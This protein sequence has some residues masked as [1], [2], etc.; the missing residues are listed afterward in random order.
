MKLRIRGN[1]IR[2][3]L[4]Q[5]EVEQLGK[6]G[7]IEEAIEFGSSINEKLTY[8]LVLSGKTAEII[9]K[10]D[11]GKIAVIIPRLVADEWIGSDRIGIG[12]EQILDKDKF[13]SILIEKDF[14]CLTERANEDES[15]NF[16]HPDTG[17][18]C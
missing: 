15:D 2:F 11:S 6:R 18:A 14:A 12:G 8:A 9:T 1:S 10:Y 13:L 4:T 3:R 16:P 17:K 5:S 7:Q